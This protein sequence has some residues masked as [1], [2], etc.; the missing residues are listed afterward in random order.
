[1]TCENLSNIKFFWFIMGSFTGLAG[2]WLS[3]WY[4]FHR[5]KK[6][7]KSLMY[8]QDKTNNTQTNFI[9]I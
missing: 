3:T 2:G 6:I 7:T 9:D 4:Y 1:M 5:K 8:N